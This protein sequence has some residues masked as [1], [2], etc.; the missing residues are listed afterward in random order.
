MQRI[1]QLQRQASSQRKA[2]FMI[3]GMALLGLGFGAAYLLG[4]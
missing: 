1:E 2:L 3:A 4:I